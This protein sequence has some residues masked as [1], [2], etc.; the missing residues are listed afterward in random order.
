MAQCL[1]GIEVYR[2]VPPNQEETLRE[3][4]T[5]TSTS[6]SPFFAKKAMQRGK[7]YPVPMH[8]P[9]FAVETYVP[10]GRGN[11][12]ESG[13]K[14]IEKCLPAGTKIDVSSPWQRAKKAHELFSHKLSVP[15]F[16]PGIVPGT[17]LDCPRNKPGEIGLPLR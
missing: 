8:L 4:K 2:A 14:E 13:R 6:P 9:F 1:Q 12:S 16:V 7:K 3:K 17:N 5:Y 10:E 11:G 15:P